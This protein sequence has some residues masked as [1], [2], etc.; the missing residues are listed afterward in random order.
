MT[1]AEPF[2]FPKQGQVGCL[3]V[4]GFTST[5][6]D[7]RACGEYLAQR[8]ITSKGILLAGHGTSPSDLAQTGLN[9][10]LE[11][12]RAGYLELKKHTPIVFALGISFAGNLLVSLGKELDL[13]G[14]V[15]VG[16]PLKFRHELS[17]RTLYFAYKML[18]INYQKKWYQKSLDPEIRKLRPNY[19]SIPIN[20]ARD[21]LTAIQRSRK[22]LSEVTCP[23]L[24]VQSTTDHAVDEE[25]IKILSSELG[26]SKF[27]VEWIPDRYHVVLIDH[28][29]EE[30]FARIAEFI[31]DNSR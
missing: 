22:K 6:Y 4:H 26:T 2:F 28:G 30:V 20:C 3:L 16:M 29:K 8:G 11:S 19:Q 24:A 18:G 1:G 15:V 10:W 25:T 9:D 7:V 23:V 5:T 31:K 17:F 12:V 13:A 27:Q 14:L 21:V